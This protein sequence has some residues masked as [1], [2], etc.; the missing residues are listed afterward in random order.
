MVSLINCFALYVNSPSK[1]KDFELIPKLK[2][3]VISSIYIFNF[4]YTLRKS[5]INGSFAQTKA[6]FFLVIA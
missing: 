4:I 1:W 3:E 5:K 6:S 2:K